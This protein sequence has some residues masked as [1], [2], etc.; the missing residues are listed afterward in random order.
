[1]T[2]INPDIGKRLIQR[3]IQ[4]IDHRQEPTPLIFILMN[5][6]KNLSPSE[7]K[8]ITVSK[9][10]SEFKKSGRL[11]E[12]QEYK[13][14]PLW[15]K[16]TLK[17]KNFDK[18]N[19]LE[20][21]IKN[22]LEE[23]LLYENQTTNFFI[24]HIL[25]KFKGELIVSA[26]RIKRLLDNIAE[27]SPKTGIYQLTKN[28]NIIA[29]RKRTEIMNNLVKLGGQYKFKSFN[30]KKP[31]DTCYKDLDSEIKK[32][33]PK[34][35]RRLNEAVLFWCKNNKP[36]IMFYITLTGNEPD[37][38]L[39]DVSKKLTT[40]EGFQKIMIFP[41]KFE[42]SFKKM[43]EHWDYILLEDI[44]RLMY[45]KG[46]TDKIS[47]PEKEEHHEKKKRVYA[48][49]VDN[50]PYKVGS[51][52]KYFRLVLEEPHIQQNAEPGQFINILCP[53]INTKEEK[54]VFDTE[55][56]YLRN[57]RN[58]GKVEQIKPLLRRPISIHRIYY[59]A[60]D[61]KT[62]KGK[63][64]L[65]P[66]INLRG[67]VRNRF[68]ILVKVVGI[69]TKALSEVKKGDR[70]DIIGPLG[71]PIIIN[72]SLKKALLVAGG[73]GIAPLYALAE[74]LRWNN[75][76]VVLFLGTYSEEDLG[77]LNYNFHTDTGY[78]MDKI[79]A[80]R[81][82]DEFKE[83]GIKV[84]ICTLKKSQKGF[85]EGTVDSI[86]KTYLNEKKNS[87][88]DTEV[89]TC[90]PKEMMKEIVNISE[91]F[92]LSH[93]VLLEEIMGCGLGVCLSC[94]CPTKNNNEIEYKRICTEGPTFDAK[95]IAWDRY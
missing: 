18:K 82:S 1:M 22:E 75:I 29:N 63:R 76:E 26:Q 81:F 91:E 94:V 85:T 49:V 39:T 79:E 52:L 12:T 24:Q 57:L 16:W 89:F 84:S 13:D 27:K 45:E 4:I 87:L 88:E 53:T 66:E 19:S 6:Y 46:I 59:E 2:S 70:L 32:I 65:P 80:K 95:T 9:I 34:S 41:E 36:F 55:E 50:I 35:N 43:E 60:F 69:G 56:T 71:K 74:K 37:S 92:N 67:G 77:V 68:D 42:K 38:V 62:L 61:P 86:F 47:K 44:E 73:I 58:K 54:L 31:L 40:I 21:K 28:K 8:S 64:H 72:P 23:I 3:A 20:T 93:Q 7:I 33:I 90:G 15:R 10:I 5:L 83:M 51:E 11:Q 48:K 17:N 30:T 78:V 14:T 25:S